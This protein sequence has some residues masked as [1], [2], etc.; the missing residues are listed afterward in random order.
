V[1]PAVIP[2][3]PYC[4]RDSKLVAGAAIYGTG[5]PDLAKQ[6]FW[7]CGPCDAYVGCHRGTTNALGRLADA[8]LRMWKSRAHSA[9]DGHW[10]RKVDAVIAQNGGKAP[11]GVKTEFR[12]AAY[13]RLARDLGIEMKDCHIGMFD[14]TTC[15]R[16]IQICITWNNQPITERV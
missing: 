7:R 11:K 9:F 3:C 15:E 6:Q 16:T 2:V 14:R 8:T 5:N 4:R 10:K 12:T 13:M 1:E